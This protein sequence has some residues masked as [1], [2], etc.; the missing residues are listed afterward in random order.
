M[1]DVNNTLII[2]E[3]EDCDEG[4]IYWRK[5]TSICHVCY[6]TGQV[7]YDTI[8]DC[9]EDAMIDYPDAVEIYFYDE[10]DYEREEKQE[11][12]EVG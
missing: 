12:V 1:S 4:T 11:I 10:E 7:E 5:G 8:Y 6:G 3:C 2:T 9:I